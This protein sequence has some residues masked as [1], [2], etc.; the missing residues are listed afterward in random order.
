MTDLT[1]ALVAEYGKSP[2]TPQNL[3]EIFLRKV[4]VY[5]TYKQKGTKSE[6]GSL[7]FTYKYD[8]RCPNMISL[9]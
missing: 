2:V 1:I 5:I 9:F 4:K 7:T 3:A 8:V 6:T